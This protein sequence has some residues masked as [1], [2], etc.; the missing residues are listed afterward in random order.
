M[1]VWPVSLKLPVRVSSLLSTVCVL[2]DWIGPG[3]QILTGHQEARKTFSLW[4]ISEKASRFGK[5]AAMPL[6]SL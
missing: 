4:S 5:L 3:M 2:N 1:K 6:A